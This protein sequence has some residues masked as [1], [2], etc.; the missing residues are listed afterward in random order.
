MTWTFMGPFNLKRRWRRHLAPTVQSMKWV[1]LK[2]VLIFFWWKKCRW[3]F[4]YKVYK[5]IVLVWAANVKAIVEL[6]RE[7]LNT[8]SEK[9]CR[10]F[11]KK[12]SSSS[13]NVCFFLCGQKKVMSYSGSNPFFM[14]FCLSCCFCLSLSSLSWGRRRRKWG[15]ISL[16]ISN[17]AFA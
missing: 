15:T 14:A 8:T 11:V 13:F 1:N 7:F 12:G 4:I 16:S 5:S 3:Y 10:L 17:L 2:G 6:E 9:Q